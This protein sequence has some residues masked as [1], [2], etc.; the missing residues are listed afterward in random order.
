VQVEF[1]TQ[2]E[3]LVKHN[4][5]RRVECIMILKAIL[6]HEKVNYSFVLLLY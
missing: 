4:E 3:V 6:F 2:L 5:M 1:C